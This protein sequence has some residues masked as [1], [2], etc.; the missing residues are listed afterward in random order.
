MENLKSSDNVLSYKDAVLFVKY[1][2]YKCSMANANVLRV[3]VRFA[4]D[5][6]FRKTVSRS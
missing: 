6:V 4:V 2:K 5:K 1:C 3:R